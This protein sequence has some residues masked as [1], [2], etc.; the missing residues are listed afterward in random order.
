MT[1]QFRAALLASAACSVALSMYPASVAHS[2]VATASK[3]NPSEMR[4]PTIRQMIVKLRNPKAAELTAP[5]GADR[6]TALSNRAGVSMRAHRAMAL[7]ASVLR[8]D[9]PL[10][11]SEARAIAAKMAEDPEVEYAEPDMPVHAQ[12]TPPD[13]SFLLRQWHF[14]APTTTFSDVNIQLTGPN[15][16]FTPTGA[17]NL[18]G[19]WNVTQGSPSIVVAL[20]DNG[21]ALTH[22]EVAAALLP[23]YDFV[24]SDVGAAGGLPAN[25]VA[26]DGNGPDPDP[27]DPGDWIT[28]ADRTNFPNLCD[29]PSAPPGDID[30]TWHGTHMAGTIVGQW[31]V[32]NPP[33]PGTST[34]GIAPNARLL[35][36]RA[37]G[38][39]GGTSSD[40]HDAI[41]WAAGFAVPNAP[42][43]A[44]PARIINLSLGAQSTTC[45]QTYADAI[46]A[47]S[48]QALVIAAAGNEATA[49]V[50]EPARCPGV[51]AVTAHTINGDNADYANI[52]PEIAIS[53]PGGGPP[54]QLSTNAALD[55]DNGFYTW[56]S[57][58][59]G[60]T[61]PTSTETG[62]TRSGPAIGGFTGTSGATA[63]VSGVAALILSAKPTLTPIQLRAALVGNTR[64]HPAGGYCAAG[65]QGANQCGS[66]LLDA[67]AAMNSVV[68]P[69]SAG[70]GGALPAGGGGGGALPFAQL[71]LLGLFA[72]IARGRRSD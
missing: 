45:S 42:A 44:N 57:I 1:K 39:C 41:L 72:L 51:L 13:P 16:M 21:V 26:N 48:G 56:S 5:L 68:P 67:T 54:T 59:F 47:V 28:A 14:F 33:L 19:A 55:T 22:P 32:G 9:T 69:S 64:P 6:V 36:V 66:G 2:T 7:G 37:L 31:G 46:A 23:G 63:N 29:D 53:S 27:S 50:D 34:A 12:T 17:A 18:P 11:L 35:P 62:G 8:L 40:V 15:K 43:N 65:Q 3:K 52:G 38:K 24:S 49:A 61:T 71:L 10:K 70:G 20:V 25:F 4:E 30:S 58:L 60:A